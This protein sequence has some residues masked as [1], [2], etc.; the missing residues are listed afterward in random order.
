[1]DRI[2]AAG[3]YIAPFDGMNEKGLFIGIAM[4][5]SVD[6]PSDPAKETLTGVQMVRRILDTCATVKEAGELVSQYNVDFFPG[7]HLH[8]LIADGAGDSLIVEFTAEG[9]LLIPS[10]RYA[11]ATNFVMRGEEQETWAGRCDRF[12]ALVAASS[13][14]GTMTGDRMMEL[15]SSVKQQLE[16]GRTEWSAVYSTDGTVTVCLGMDYDRHYSFQ[17]KP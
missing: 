4:V 14:D 3:G 1:M 13:E 16:K 17:M 8:F 2:N 7:P 12:D 15:L 11:C 10:S 5:R 6:V 9:A